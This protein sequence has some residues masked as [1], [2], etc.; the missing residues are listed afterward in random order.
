M[1]FVERGEKNPTLDKLGKLAIALEVSLEE[2][3]KGI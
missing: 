3:F 1:G 2:L